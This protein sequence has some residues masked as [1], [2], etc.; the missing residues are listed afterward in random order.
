VIKP[1][2]SVTCGRAD[3]SAIRLM[4]HVLQFEPNR[5]LDAHT[6]L[7]HPYFTSGPIAPPTLPNNGLNSNASSLALPPHV[8]A[9]ATQMSAAV[10]AQQRQQQQ[11]QH[12]IQQI[13]PYQGN[14]MQAQAQAQAQVQAQQQQMAQQQYMMQQ[15][16]QRMAAGRSLRL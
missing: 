12:Q 16:Q 9:R 6:A 2:A 10:T 14:Q 11:Q 13:P 15:Q 8:A 7:Q 4:E 1:S 5:R 3:K